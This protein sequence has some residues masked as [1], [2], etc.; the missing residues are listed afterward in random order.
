MNRNYETQVRLYASMRSWIECEAVRQLYAVGTLD[1]VRRVVGFPDLQPGRLTPTGTACV[2]QDLIYPHLIGEDVGCGMGLFKTDLVLSDA[3][4]S[5]WAELPFDLE[6]PSGEIESAFFPEH[7]V[8]STEFDVD[9]GTI[10]HGNHFAELQVIEDVLD[11]KA[12]R[13]LGVG[14]KQLLMLIH[15]GSRGLGESLQ[16]G[17]DGQGQTEGVACDSFEAAE[18]LRDHDHALRWAKANRMRIASRFAGELGVT[19]ERVWDGCH[20]SITPQTSDGNTVWVH[21]K[22]AVSVEGPCVVIPGSRG[23][24]SFLVKPIGDIGSHAWSLAH[25]AGRKWAR[26]E[27]RLRM[28]KRF[29]PQH[30]MQTALGS[31]VICEERG[32]LYEEAPDAYKNIED[33]IADMA[34]AGLVSVVATLRP[35]LT[36]KTRTLGL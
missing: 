4:L 28:R 18:Y 32:L 7:G 27:S 9:L 11:S 17:R 26:S 30:L 2:T 13:T 14:R 15:S 25:G 29:S 31:R 35:L 5:R 36:Y 21:R 22:G 19:A 6:S 12:F 1:G 34:E 8:L 33:V 20:N 24:L 10:G 3:K 23:S 16:R